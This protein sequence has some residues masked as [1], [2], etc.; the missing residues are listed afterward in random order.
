MRTVLVVVAALALVGC[1]LNV[2]SPDL[3]VLTR[4]GQGQNLTLLVNDGGTIRCN[5]GSKKTLPDHT[6]LVAR[7]L[8][9]SLDDDAKKGLHISP[10]GN[11]VYSYKVK[12]QDGTITFPDTAAAA[13]RELARA[14][15][16]ATQAVQGPCTAAAPG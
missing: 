4:T 5:G 11:S 15:L 14:E 9:K 16:F 10:A 2:S 12:L 3:F 6:L 7:D 8:A 13:H 1:G